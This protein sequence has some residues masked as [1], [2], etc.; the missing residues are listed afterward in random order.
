MRGDFTS[1][2]HI[3]MHLYNYEIVLKKIQQSALIL[4]TFTDF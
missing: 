3:I 1:I 4:N 2:F